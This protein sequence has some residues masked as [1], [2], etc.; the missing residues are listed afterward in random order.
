MF[1]S[2]G[3]SV[4]RLLITFSS[5]IVVLIIITAFISYTAGIASEARINMI[6]MTEL[7][8]QSTNRMLLSKATILNLHHH[9]HLE[10]SLLDDTYQGGKL[11]LG[12]MVATK[13]NI[14]IFISV[15][16]L[17]VKQGKVKGEV[18][19]YSDEERAK[20]CSL[21]YHQPFIEEQVGAEAKP[22]AARYVLNL[23][24]C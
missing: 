12:E 11:T 5:L 4:H 23:K 9:L 6:K 17:I 18:D 1:K 21:T 15:G 14:P 2:D 20:G 7:Q 24:A 16:R 3:Y 8:L 19:F 13:E 22:H 10:A